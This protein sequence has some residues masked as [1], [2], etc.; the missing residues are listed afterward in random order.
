M[1]P[2]RLAPSH[3]GP[4]CRVSA[5][6]SQLHRRT[7]QHVRTH[8]QARCELRSRAGK[9]R[10]LVGRGNVRG[11]GRG[12]SRQGVKRVDE[13]QPR[14]TGTCQLLPSRMWRGARAGD[15]YWCPGFCVGSRPKRFLHVVRSRE[16]LSS[17]EKRA[18]CADCVGVPSGAA[19]CGRRKTGSRGRAGVPAQRVSP[20]GAAHSGGVSTAETVRRKRAVT[21]PEACTPARPSRWCS[22]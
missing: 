5:R 19:F 21:A 6:G 14:G 17:G 16:N 22:T 10:G 8:L 12:Y 2:A 4:A 9:S 13:G 3:W 11:G 7:W 18:G 20:T 15:Q 1:L